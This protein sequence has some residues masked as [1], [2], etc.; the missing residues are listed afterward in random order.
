MA[1]L[2]AGLQGTPDEDV[3]LQLRTQE[4]TRDIYK[5]KRKFMPARM[6]VHTSE[7]VTARQSASCDYVARQS[8][9][10]TSN[11][12]PT[13][14]GQQGPAYIEQQGTASQPIRVDYN[15]QLIMGNQKTPVGS[16]L[17][18]SNGSLTGVETNRPGGF[19]SYP[20]NTT[21]KDRRAIMGVPEPSQDG[22][23]S[24]PCCTKC[25]LIPVA[26]RW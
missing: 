16:S 11:L 10:I 15:P 9:D 17:A 1:I 13:W 26:M 14:I 3:V 8:I 19:V 6:P 12:S 20:C 4:G 18:Q 25:W 5:G 21:S 23:R 2:P 7:Q 22:R 24:Y